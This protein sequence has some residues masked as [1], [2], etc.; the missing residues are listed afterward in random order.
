M[1]GGEEGRG[2]EGREKG[3]GRGRQGEGGRE[4]GAGRGRQ[5]E[6]GRE[7]KAGR[8]CSLGERKA[9][10]SRTKEHSCPAMMSLLH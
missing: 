2:E 9:K 3:A 6:G 7:R 10:S 1:Q 5:G 4:K 8:G